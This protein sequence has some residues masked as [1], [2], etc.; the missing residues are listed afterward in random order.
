VP[1][2]RSLSLRFV[3]FS[4]ARLREEI[5]RAACGD[6]SAPRGSDQ[7]EYLAS[8]LS[9]AEAK[10][11]TLV[12]E[13]PYVDRHYLEEFS[14]Y[15]ASAL[16][17]PKSQTTRIHVFRS[18]VTPK[19]LNKL[20]VGSAEEQDEIRRGY[21]GFIVVRPIP[22]V[23]IGRT[24]LAPYSDKPSRNYGPPLNPHHVHLAGA[25]LRIEGV[26]F[27]QQDRAVGACATTALWSALS[28]VMRADGGRASTPFAV[29]SAANK[30]VLSGRPF[31]ASSGLELGQMLG[32]I[33][34]LGYSPHVLKPEDQSATFQL[35]LKCYVGSGIPV[36]LQ[37]KRDGEDGHAVTV[38]G[39]AEDRT[40]GLLELP[41]KIRF[42]PI[43]KLY[44]HD[45][46][47]GPYAR[48]Q[49]AASPH[50]LA[51]KAS[52]YESGFEEFEKPSNIWHAIIPLYPKI[53]LSAE[54]L[55]EVAHEALP[56][57]RMLVEP[58]RRD[59]ITVELK[60]VRGGKYVAD[61][62]SAGL[63]KDRAATFAA[64]AHLSR[65]VGIIR[66]HVGDEW[67]LDFA[68]DTTEILRS[69]PPLAS[70]IAVVTRDAGHVDAVRKAQQSGYGVGAVIA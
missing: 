69:S 58:S 49:F 24:I 39:F 5:L 26:P 25:E 68:C 43:E 62:M 12:I 40:A 67:L 53:R 13:A 60:F 45:D 14:G 55:A 18:R 50:D 63:A 59:R 31:P 36:I 35:A 52:P 32:A 66:F 29:T 4:R 20:L 7:V 22:S 30:H 64:R 3:Q 41:S 44:V 47:L 56:L 9:Q 48:M 15:Y 38:T 42:R 16:R 51:I 6:A 28:R 54:D 34:E 46:R 70:V 19:R 21:L 33:R 65:Y 37:I 8:Y 23:P 27:Q 57:V 61:A 2:D 11:E 1:T 10:A 17:P